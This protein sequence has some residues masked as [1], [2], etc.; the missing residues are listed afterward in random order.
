MSGYM[1]L[2]DIKGESRQSGSTGKFTSGG[3]S[4][5]FYPYEL[6]NVYIS[7]YNV[8][9]SG[10]QGP[11]ST[12]FGAAGPGK[13]TVRMPMSKT[14]SPFRAL[15]TSGSRSKSITIVDNAPE[16]EQKGSCT[17]TLYGVKIADTAVK[18]D[19]LPA[20]E[21]TLSYEKIEWTYSEITIGYTMIKQTYK[22]L[23]P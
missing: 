4:P 22:R 23:D 15:S 11:G 18:A 1:K 6:D 14:P 5:S 8:G 3:S 16:S 10:S 9:G 20:E 17:Y 19:P 13:M 7:S 2:G 12:K 21:L